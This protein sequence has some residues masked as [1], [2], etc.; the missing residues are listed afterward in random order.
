MRSS[1]RS[2][3]SSARA[4]GQWSSSDVSVIMNTRWNECVCE[5]CAVHK[6]EIDRK[7]K[8]TPNPLTTA[9]QRPH[10][11]CTQKQKW[12]IQRPVVMWFISVSE[13]FTNVL[14]YHFNPMELLFVCVCVSS[15]WCFQ[16]KVS[17]WMFLWR[18]GRFCSSSAEKTSDFLSHDQRSGSFT[19]ELLKM[20]RKFPGRKR[21]LI[22]TI[23]TSFL[24]L[25][26]SISYLYKL[27]QHWMFY[28]INIINAISAVSVFCRYFLR[29]WLCF[30][31][32]PAARSR[33]VSR[34]R[35][36]GTDTQIKS[37][38]LHLKYRGSS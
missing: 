34:R 13:T 6:P 23:W 22:L 29:L 26:T 25:H 19:A 12:V 30:S 3:V 17:N 21:E 4:E 8:L 38:K 5:E 36:G 7:H 28:T 1:W 14:I 9:T 33:T 24:S 16:V 35:C 2:A 32:L 15:H 18:S 11:H 20:S 37:V 27:F 31:W 10:S